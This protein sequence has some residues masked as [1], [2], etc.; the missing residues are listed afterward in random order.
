[1]TPRH[2]LRPSQEHKVD[3]P[4]RPDKN[5]KIQVTHY[6]NFRQRIHGGPMH[7]VLGHKHRVSKSDWRADRSAAHFDA[8]EGMETWSQ[9]YAPK[10]QR[11]PKLNERP[12]GK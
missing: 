11:M 5:E 10:K 4:E 9:K 6:R 12:Y 2:L 7:S 3:P 8:F 1:M